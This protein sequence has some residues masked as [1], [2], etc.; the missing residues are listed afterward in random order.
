MIYSGTLPLTPGWTSL[1]LLCAY[2]FLQIVPRIYEADTWSLIKLNLSREKPP[3]DQDRTTDFRRNF[4]QRMEYWII[5]SSFMATT[6]ATNFVVSLNYE[7][8]MPHIFS[9]G[10]IGLGLMF[11]AKLM[12]YL[13]ALVEY[14]HLPEKLNALYRKCIVLLGLAVTFTPKIVMLAVSLIIKNPTSTQQTYSSIY[15][16]L[17]RQ[18]TAQAQNTKPKLQYK[19]VYCANLTA[20]SVLSVGDSRLHTIVAEDTL[21]KIALL[22][23]LN[24][25]E[26]LKFNPGLYYWKEV[27]FEK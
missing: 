17:S 23:G 4:I 8:F 24:I 26:L 16:E 5:G 21:E 18:R 7:L 19:E 6:V 12:Y 1:G 13:R 22:Y 14:A 20:G 10:L 9:V 3:Q 15:H 27:R 25:Q 11:S 2:R